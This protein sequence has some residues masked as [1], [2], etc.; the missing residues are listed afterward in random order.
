MYL[1]LIESAVTTSFESTIPDQIGYLLLDL[2]TITVS[3]L[4]F[5]RDPPFPR[6]R[7]VRLEIADIN[8]SPLFILDTFS[9]KQTD[10]A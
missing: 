9:F 2:I 4:S 10:I 8:S 6:Q 5:L 3:L 7:K 1:C